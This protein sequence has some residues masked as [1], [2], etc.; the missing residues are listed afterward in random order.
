[1][2][3]LSEILPEE[4]LPAIED[5]LTAVDQEIF[6]CKVQNQGHKDLDHIKNELIEMRDGKRKQPL[7]MIGGIIVD[8]MDW[9]QP[10][11]EKFNQVC[12]LLRKHFHLRP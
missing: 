10:S 1:M 6:E 5:A 2:I 4:I 7:E 12:S 9:S 11:L 3:G 8:S